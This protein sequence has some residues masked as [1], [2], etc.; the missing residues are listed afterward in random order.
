MPTGPISARARRAPVE[1]DASDYDRE[2]TS[3]ENTVERSRTAN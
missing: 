3:Q 1:V 2:D